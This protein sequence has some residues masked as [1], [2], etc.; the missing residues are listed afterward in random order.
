MPFNTIEIRSKLDTETIIKRLKANTFPQN[1]PWNIN[2]FDMKQPAVKTYSCEINNDAFTLRARK[3][4][5]RR[6]SRPFGYG[7][8]KQNK[9]STTIHITV[10]PHIG[11]IITWLAF[12]LLSLGGVLHSIELE[13]YFSL[14]PGILIMTGLCVFYYLNLKYDTK[15]MHLFVQKIVKEKTT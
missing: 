12:F 15:D 10:V 11:S 8:I 3:T 7:E 5:Q 6:Q 1:A 2:E 13:N 4:N 14:I 9:K